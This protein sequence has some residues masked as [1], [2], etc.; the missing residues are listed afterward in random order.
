MNKKK[1]EAFAKEA[2]KGIKKPEDL[3]DFSQML[4]WMSILVTKKTNPLSPIT[5]AMERAVNV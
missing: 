5:T 3:T 2:A 1:L 4:K